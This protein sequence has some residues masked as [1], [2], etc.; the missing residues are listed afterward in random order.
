MA[1]AR[2]KDYIYQEPTLTEPMEDV[3][4]WA[5]TNASAADELTL[6]DYYKTL[7][8]SI[9][10]TSAGGGTAV[11]MLKT[12]VSP[13]DIRNHD[14]VISFYVDPAEIAEVIAISIK[15]SDT[16]ASNFV[17][18]SI[19]DTNTP[20]GVSGWHT[21]KMS[22]TGHSSV[23]NVET[24]L[25]FFQKIR[26]RLNTTGAATTPTV[27]IDSVRFVPS[28]PKATYFLTFDD[29][30]EDDLLVTSYLNSKN[31]KG[32]FFISP[33][34]IGT[35]DFLTKDQLTTMQSQGHLIASHSWDHELLQTDSLTP[36]EAIASIV[37]ATDWLNDNGFTKGS[38]IW[39]VPGGSISTFDWDEDWTM[40][41]PYCDIIRHTGTP[42][43]ASSFID[44]GNLFTSDFD[45]PAGSEDLLGQTY[46]DN[47]SLVIL[48]FH[49]YN[50]AVV[51]GGELTQAFKDFIDLLASKV[52]SG[53]AVVKTL[54]EI[55]APADTVPNNDMFNNNLNDAF[56]E[57]A[58]DIYAS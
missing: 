35:G 31:L 21:I 9:A 1:N 46:L 58:N 7:K 38:R 43:D 57:S 49:S 32:S 11:E 6:V 30:D 48:G 27:V 28:L 13:I 18:A 47:G 36:E 12:L 52:A 42:G 40:L 29:G 37:K 55:N 33:A 20:T 8:K 10:L 16:G 44:Y 22:C 41:K 50:A 3:A 56:G 19:F 34:K 24:A 45:D 15:L 14:M 26:F 53:E 5:L 25:Q 51:S 4:S 54:D 23:N 39:G 17:V 2:I